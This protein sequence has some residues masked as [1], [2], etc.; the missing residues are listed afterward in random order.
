MGA[1]KIATILVLAVVPLIGGPASDF[2]SIEAKAHYEKALDYGNQDL[3]TPAILELN[4]A[5]AAEPGNP[6]S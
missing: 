5:I 1:G 3:W 2:K 6:K 4:R